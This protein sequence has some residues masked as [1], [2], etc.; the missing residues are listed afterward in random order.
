MTAPAVSPTDSSSWQVVLVGPERKVVLYEP[1]RNRFAVA[2]SSVRPPSTRTPSEAYIEDTDSSTIARELTRNGGSARE[3]PP[4]APSP[5]SA[6]TTRAPASL[7][8][9][10]YQPI[11]HSRSPGRRATSPPRH[12]PLP[13]PPSSPF[14]AVDSDEEGSG[15]EWWG[16]GRG[17]TASST[18]AKDGSYFELLSEANSRVNSPATTRRGLE[19]GA[20]APGTADPALGEGQMNQGYTAKF[21]E[22]VQLLGRGGQGTVYLVRHVLNGE[23]LGLYALKKIPV[24]DSTP[25]LLRILREVHLLESL[26]HPN[27]ISY[28]HAWLETSLPRTFAPPTPTLHVLMAFANGRSL[29]GFVQQ[30]AGAPSEEGATS[31]DRRKSRHRARRS[32][33]AP[34]VHLL[35][36]EDVL[37]LF[38]DVVTGLGFLHSRNILHLDM[39]AENVLLQW[40]ENALLP[41]CQLSDFGNATDDSYHRERLG[42][43]GTL[44]YT[45]PEAWQSDPHMGK[46]LPPDRATDLWGLGLVLHLLCFF[47]LPWKSGDDTLSL[48]REI[49][50]YRGFFPSD[51]LPAYPPS[52]PPSSPLLIAR[53]DLPLSLLLLLS[54]LINRSPSSRPSCERVSSALPSIRIDAADLAARGGLY[55]MESE[56]GG[57]VRV[58]PVRGSF[59]STAQMETEPT[60]ERGGGAA[61]GRARALLGSPAVEAVVR[62]SNEE[63]PALVSARRTKVSRGLTL[64]GNGELGRKSLAAGVAVA[65]LL[66]IPSTPTSPSSA[67]PS[68]P[69]WLTA[70]LLLET[71]LDVALAEVWVTALL[72]MLHVAVVKV[73]ERVGG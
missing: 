66:L 56:Q 42:G 40:D 6:Q 46:L 71:A 70:L 4:P 37:A 32:G 2:S 59:P 1:R 18:K 63:I 30:R 19:G 10:C 11:P 64:G 26:S 52:S 21:F 54:S 73:V 3:T 48:E 43:S 7:C 27:I 29:Q 22:E 14:A 60:V 36:V 53:H 51:A 58:A 57:L 5:S 16:R 69:T 45:P 67:S 68:L 9:L 47:A 65:K 28:H 39:K 31:R 38:K 17:R 62:E 61:L 12:A 50:A 49:R 24:G 72:A 13:L 33:S 20:E 55:S 25:S 15:D 41:R 44:E 8:P 35:G 34:A 23:A